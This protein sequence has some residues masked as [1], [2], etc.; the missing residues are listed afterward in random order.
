MSQIKATP[1]YTKAFNAF[2]ACAI[3]CHKGSAEANWGVVRISEARFSVAY[4]GEG[5]GETFEAHK[6]VAAIKRETVAM[7]LRKGGYRNDKGQWVI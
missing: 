5:I 2:V 6:A 4:N 3:A 7:Y 1:A